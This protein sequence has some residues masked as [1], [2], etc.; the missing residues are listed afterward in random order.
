[1]TAL[2]IAG[3]LRGYRFNYTSEDQLQQ[4]I[5]AALVSEGL[6]VEREARIGSG[7]RIDLLVGNVGI[8][9]KLHGSPANV[10]RQVTR[11]LRSGMVDG[12]VLVTA[13]VRHL[14]IPGVETVTL[15]GQG[16]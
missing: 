4:A 5:E 15:A 11:Y 2:E 8:E 14:R 3:I 13:R 9:V 10:E 6:S 1:M 16:L 12:V 7:C